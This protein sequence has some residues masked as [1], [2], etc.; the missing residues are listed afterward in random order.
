MTD[1]THQGHIALSGRGCR[2]L[3]YPVKYVLDG[4]EIHTTQVP[5]VILQTSAR[6]GLRHSASPASSLASLENVAVRASLKGHI[7]AGRWGLL[8]MDDTNQ[9]ST[10]ARDER[11]A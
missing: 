11:R 4:L 6:E 1:G 5:R 2:E 9:S 7:R 3:V 8:E 10:T